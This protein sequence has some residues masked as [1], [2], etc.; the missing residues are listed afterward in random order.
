MYIEV[1]IYDLWKIQSRQW[2]YD[3]LF[4]LFPK[5]VFSLTCIYNSQLHCILKINKHNRECHTEFSPLSCTEKTTNL[6][7]RRSFI[8]SR[9]LF[10]VFTLHNENHESALMSRGLVKKAFFKLLSSPWF[11][12]F[13][14]TRLPAS[15]SKPASV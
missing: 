7:H 14:S 15:Q 11:H 10:T 6:E 12:K 9:D 13:S 4:V 3:S 2:N 1:S 5:K 8:L